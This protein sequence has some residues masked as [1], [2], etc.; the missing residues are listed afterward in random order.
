VEGD[1][2]GKLW[3]RAVTDDRTIRACH[4]GSR[5]LSE[6]TG[7]AARAVNATFSRGSGT[8]DVAV[9]GAPD[10]AA[11][12]AR[13]SH[14]AQRADVDDAGARTGAARD[15]LVA[16]GEVARA[17]SSALQIAAAAAFDPAVA[18]AG[19]TQLAPVYSNAPDEPNEP[20]PS[21]ISNNRA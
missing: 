11:T 1:T 8:G 10:V 15:A 12:R 4:R 14:P 18:C 20:H 7:R 13:A 9:A 5:A 17:C 19:Q 21:T 6:V 3:T 16:A 2:P